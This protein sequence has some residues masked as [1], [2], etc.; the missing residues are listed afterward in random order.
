[1]N[2][3]SREPRHVGPSPT[4]VSTP[5]ALLPLPSL[6]SRVPRAEHPGL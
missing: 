6:P 3:R 5:P 2:D 1:M 4:P